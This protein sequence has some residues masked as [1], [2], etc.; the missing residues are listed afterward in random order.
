MRKN[1]ESGN[2]IFPETFPTDANLI[3]WEQSQAVNLPPPDKK[4]IVGQD[5]RIYAHTY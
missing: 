5:Q 2:T 1:T 4:P 3:E